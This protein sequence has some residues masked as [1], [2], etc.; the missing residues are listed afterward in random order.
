[1]K[2]P[3]S[4]PRRGRLSYDRRHMRSFSGL[5][6]WIREE[7]GMVTTES[8]T[9]R[10][11]VAGDFRAAA[12]FHEFG[13]DF[14]CG[15]GKSLREACDARKV[16]PDLVLDELSR[17]CYRGDGSTPRFSEWDADTLAA[18]IVS[19]H[20]G[21]VRRALP[22]LTEHLRKLA[23]AHGG[24]RPELYEVARRFESIA[25]EMADH[26]AKEERILF[27]YIQSLAVAVRGS[28]RLPRSPFGSIDNPIQ[29]MEQEHDWVG[30]AMNR[31]RELTKDYAIPADG[32]T[33]YR[34]AMQELAAFER[35]L[36][37][38]VHLENNVL[39][40][41]ARALATPAVA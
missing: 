17:A 35:D 18:Y 14:C 41:K 40:P 38:H 24:R 30:Q 3:L 28:D 16:S 10:D 4:I 9:V 21:Y 32:C 11:I 26:M 7:N 31:I 20:H 27:P 37:E 1:M 22:A 39:F 8:T 5:L 13:I 19:K 15:G 33:T 6:R 34:I 36:H 29:V 12:V 2:S 25:A 23:R